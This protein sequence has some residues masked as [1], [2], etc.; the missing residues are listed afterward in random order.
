VAAGS[1]GID[2]IGAITRAAV[3]WLHARGA[4]P[5]IMPAMG[6]HG[7]GTAE[8]QLDLLASY[9]ITEAVMGVP[10]RADMDVRVIG[11]TP[12]GF[13]VHTSTVALD[14]DAVL[15]IN[16]VKPHTDF[17]SATVGSG[18]RK[19]CAIGLGKVEGA[20]TCH[21]VATRIGH[22]RVI[23]EVAAVATATLPRLFGLALVEDGTHHIARIEVLRGE[24]FLS[25]EPELYAQ[26]WEWMPALPLAQVDILVVDEIG[27]D[28]SGCGMDTNIIGRGVD[29]AP[30][31][32]RRTSVRTIYARSLTPAS[33]GNAVGI[34][35][36]DIV[37]TRLVE[38]MDRTISYT[39]ALSAMTPATVRIS[40]HF[41]T[42][43]ECMRAALRVAGAAP[44]EARI[45]RI[46][47]TLSLQYIVASEA[48]LEPLRERG[49][50]EILE[51]P[52]PWTFDRQ[53]NFDPAVD[54]LAAHVA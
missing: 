46:R 53:G 27:K 50:I 40:V 24:E 43:A 21:H 20:T 25:R 52:M 49:D 47:N 39:N 45:L 54:L 1:R 29:T 8:G 32:N 48:C 26:A 16:R 3:E 31:T 11:Q 42:D 38:Q 13:P 28:I 33:H 41:P 44:H 10:L 22:E 4:R 18:L 5:F 14:A 34:G 35:L 36:A 6:S 12:S 15:L 2:R 17:S 9:G 23:Q 7:G 51:P 30:M 37:S 19:M